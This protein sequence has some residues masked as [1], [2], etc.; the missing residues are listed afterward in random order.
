MSTMPMTTAADT[1][2]LSC[3]HVDAVRLSP[4]AGLKTTAQPVLDGREVPAGFRE[5]LVMEHLGMVRFVARKIQK[6]LPA[7]LEVE[8]L[9]AAGTL[10]LVDAAAKFDPATG[11]QFGSYAQFRVRGAI[12]DSLRDLDWSPRELRRKGRSIE[13]GVAA[14]TR[15]LGRTPSEAEVAAEMKLALSDYQT[16]LGELSALEMGS[17]H[18]ERGEETGE[19]EIAYV[20]DSPE[21][22]PLFHC[23]RGE[24]KQH[25]AE[26]I[27]ELPERERMVMTL[28]YYE[29][30]SMK[31]IGQVLGVVESRVS[32]LRSSAI[33]RLRAAMRSLAGR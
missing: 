25:L 9:I 8:E 15:R 1:M 6:T 27:E 3:F 23:L 19:E 5:S 29:E 14:A 13:K 32:Q 26:A 33:V 28:Y 21:E 11:V 31:E 22:Q 30:L 24:M 12:L 18:T 20:A 10:G 16:L 7:H 4:A 2:T 17:L